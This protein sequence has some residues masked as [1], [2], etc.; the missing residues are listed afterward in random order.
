MR[1]RPEIDLAAD[2]CALDQR[3][4]MAASCMTN[5]PWP[6]EKGTRMMLEVELLAH[7]GAALPAAGVPSAFCSTSLTIGSPSTVK[8]RAHSVPVRSAAP[9]PSRLTSRFIWP[10]TALG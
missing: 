5:W 6:T 7:D 4:L 3:P 9:W 10:P 1:L 8:S 2:A